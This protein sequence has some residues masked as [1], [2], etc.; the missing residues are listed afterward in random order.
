MGS[1]A[2]NFL[3][4]VLKNFDVIVG[5][6]LSLAYPLYASV[7]AIETKSPVDDQQWL[8]Y[9]VLYSMITLFEL[10][11]AKFLQWIPIWPYAKL[12]ITG[13]LVLPYF[14]GAAYVYHHYVRP[15]IVNPQTVNIWYVP[16]KKDP[17][18]KPGDIL[19]AAEK[20]IQENGTEAF[21][22]MITKADKSSKKHT[23]A[24]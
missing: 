12:M 7:R 10:T 19:T 18:G 20:Y 16:S 14:S 13:W 8:P 6:V 4:L 3:K 23:H 5:P 17:S 22:N 24:L 9:W 15:F 21:E 1:G 11:F 2:G